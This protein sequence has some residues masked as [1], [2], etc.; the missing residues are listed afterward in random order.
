M[1]R[2]ILAQFTEWLV[3]E[4]KAAKTIESYTTDVRLFQKYLTDKDV[5]LETLLTRF[6]FVQYKEHLQV[7]ELSVATIN[8]KV[9]SLK[10]YN[11]WL[12]G[13]GFVEAVYI[14]LKKDKVTVA[15]G[16]EDEVSVLTEQQVQQF[17]FHL[18][19]ESQRNR[20]IGY[21]L[22]Y[23]GVRVSELVGIKRADIDQIGAV[24]T[25]TGKGKLREVP[26]R[27]DVLEHLQTYQKGERANHKHNDSP[28]L[29]LSQRAPKMH[30]DSV[31]RW[32][33]AVGKQLGFHMHPHMLRHTFCTAL[34]RKGVELTT[35]SKL[36]GHANVNMTAKYYI[37]TSKEE[38]QLAVELL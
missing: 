7:L 25:V 37:Q 4:G 26:L 22:L 28:S 38:K 23:T 34:L 17:L 27:Q 30:R 32:L 21:L 3:E 29:L 15:S 31:R 6:L 20:L 33:E 11:D 2:T 14:K 24:L 18:E 19:K 35:V 12:F 8:K 13:K 16:S 10:V 5:D 1:P 36:A 9:N